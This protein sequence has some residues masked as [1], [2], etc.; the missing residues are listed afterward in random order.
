[1]KDEDQI[2]ALAKWEGLPTNGFYCP[3][4][5]ARSNVGYQDRCGNCDTHMLEMPP[6]YLHDLNAVHRVTMK[7]DDQQLC[8]MADLLCHITG[9][10]TRIFHAT[11]RQRCEAL[12]KVLGLWK[13]EK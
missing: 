13:E 3:R 8:R 11:A 5:N 9:F 1:M 12:L 7:L 10:H 6:H 4:C 2:I